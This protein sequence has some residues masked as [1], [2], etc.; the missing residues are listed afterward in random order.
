[1]K[2]DPAKQRAV[3]AELRALFGSPRYQAA[4]DWSDLCAMGPAAVL[5]SAWH[6]RHPAIRASSPIRSG[7]QSPPRSA[8]RR[9]PA[10][11]LD[12]GSAA[13]PN[14]VR[15]EIVMIRL[16]VNHAS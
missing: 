3:L 16:G 4:M 9:S 2:R 13:D 12:R 8:S 15:M 5:S 10:S 7:P 1:M 6:R 11:N 14:V